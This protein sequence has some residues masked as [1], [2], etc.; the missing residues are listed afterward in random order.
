M[1]KLDQRY[2]IME[3]REYENL[4]EKGITNAIKKRDIEIAKKMLKEGVEITL[5]AKITGL[6][7][8]ELAVLSF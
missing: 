4:R 3:D 7:S 2:R 1:E 8:D 5:I 6:S